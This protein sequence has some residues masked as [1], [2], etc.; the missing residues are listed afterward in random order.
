MRELNWRP[1][2]PV[3]LSVLGDEPSADTARILE[4]SA[5]RVRVATAL[6]VKSGAAVR[7]EWEGQML[8]GEVLDA[9]PGGFWVEIQHM[10]LDTAGL[11]WQ[12]QGWQR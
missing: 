8:L 7:L 5:R 10:L 1:D 6:S 11:A 4:L 9:A 3:Q 2:Q 12:R